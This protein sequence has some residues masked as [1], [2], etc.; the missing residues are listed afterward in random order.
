MPFSPDSRLQCQ[1]LACVR[2]D[3]LLFEDFNLNVRAG[4]I[5]QVHGANGA[6][7]TSLLRIVCGL[8]TPERG[9][10]LWCGERLDHRG[11]T[12]RSRLCYVGHLNG[13]KAELSPLDNLE[14]AR[15]LSPSRA[16]VQT[17]SALERAGL[18]GYEDVPCRFLSAGQK[19]RVAIAR[20]LMS[21][22]QLWVL[23]EPATALDADGVAGFQQLLESHA[24]DGGMVLI[25]SHQPLRFG[26]IHTRAVHL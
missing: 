2:G 10:V 1:D 18:A 16:D 8:A 6:G 9:E 7:K 17:V 12:F 15:S 21:G 13:V 25:T 20:L 22:A 14:A 26:D 3:N 24:H 19:R 23:D 4:E 5:C 11:D